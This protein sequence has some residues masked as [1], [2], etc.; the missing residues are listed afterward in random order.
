MNFRQHLLCER[1]HTIPFLGFR[2]VQR[3]CCI[4]I[5]CHFK[6]RI[7]FDDNRST[8]SLERHKVFLV[9]HI[10]CLCVFIKDKLM[11]LYLR[12]T[13]APQTM[14]SNILMINHTWNEDKIKKPPKWYKT[15]I[16]EISLQ[17]IFS[18]NITRFIFILKLS[19][20]S[21][22]VFCSKNFAHYLKRLIQT[23]EKIG[24]QLIK[25]CEKVLRSKYRKLFW[26][27]TSASHET[28]NIVS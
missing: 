16:W 11:R 10:L 27:F 22:K 25:N 1:E 14:T 26:T 2:C 5:A 8:Y 15:N 24:N 9:F 6:L 3:K 4:K 18:V 20:F 28:K 12:G 21:K 17:F 23:E 19:L 13:G 7:W